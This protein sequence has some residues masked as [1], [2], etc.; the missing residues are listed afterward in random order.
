MLKTIEG[1]YRDGQIQLSALPENVSEQAQVLVTF[2]EP[3]N[4]DP[5]KLRQLIDQLQTLADIQQGLNEVNAGQTRPVE[6]FAQEMQRKY[7]LS[8]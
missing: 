1:I 8:S 2:L 6:D 5:E 7:G 3:G 4:L